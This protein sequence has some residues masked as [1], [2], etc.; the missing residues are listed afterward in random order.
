MLY[1]RQ[2]IFAFASP[3]LTPFST[4]TVDDKGSAEKD[5]II[6]QRRHHTDN[7]RTKG[8][9][10]FFSTDKSFDSQQPIPMHNFTRF[11]Y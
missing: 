2:Q 1:G 9:K 5:A 4:F 6:Q 7:W 10:E 3:H 8:M 11:V